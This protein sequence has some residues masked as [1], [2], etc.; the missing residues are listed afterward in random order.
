[1]STENKV[2]L[3]EILFNYPVRKSYSRIADELVHVY[4]LRKELWEGI[5]ENLREG[6]TFTE[7][8]ELPEEFL[9]LAGMS[10]LTDVL[11]GAEVRGTGRDAFGTE[12]NHYHDIPSSGTWR[13]SF[14]PGAIIGAAQ[15]STSLDRDSDAV[16]CFGYGK[17]YEPTALVIALDPHIAVL[18]PVDPYGERRVGFQLVYADESGI[19]AYGACYFKGGSYLSYGK[20]NRLVR[21]FALQA[22]GMGT[23]REGENNEALSVLDRISGMSPLLWMNN[24]SESEL[25]EEGSSPYSGD[26]IFVEYESPWEPI[27]GGENYDNDEDYICV[28]EDSYD[29]RRV[30]GLFFDTGI[31]GITRPFRAPDIQEILRDEEKTPLVSVWRVCGCCGKELTRSDRDEGRFY[32][33]S[34]MGI[35]K[36][37][38]ED[39]KCL[40]TTMIQESTD[41]TKDG[42]SVVL[43]GRLFDLPEVPEEKPEEEPSPVVPAGEQAMEDLIREREVI[44]MAMEDGFI[45]ESE[46]SRLTENLNNGLLALDELIEELGSTSSEVACVAA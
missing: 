2:L 35:S 10:G 22:M 29:D 19:H 7:E 30:E 17:S 4:N 36:I 8:V 31:E 13:L 1:M 23:G 44:R 37:L 45:S 41:S 11:I 33:P 3:D 32:D 20:A 24:R 26:D 39:P 14:R 28:V 42:K 18:E 38:C 6:Y 40:I 16:C 27:P 46:A 43:Y 5:G 12:E 21:N 9:G 34:G 15:R 25:A